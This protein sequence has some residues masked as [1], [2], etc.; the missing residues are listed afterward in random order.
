MGRKNIIPKQKD[1]TAGS[2]RK[3]RV[4]AVEKVSKR[5]KIEKSVSKSYLELKEISD[6]VD[7]S[8]D[9]A[10][11]S[12]SG[13]SEE[14]EGSGSNSDD[15]DN[16]S[17]SVPY[18]S[19]YIFVER[20]DLRT[21]INEV[22]SFPTK[23]SVRSRM[24][25]YR[26][27]KKILVDQ[28][29]KKRFKRSCFGHLRNLPEHL[30]FNGQLVHYLL[31]RLVKNDKIRHKMWFCINNKPACF[32]LKEFCLITGLD[33]SSYPSESKMKKVLAKGDDF[34]FKVTKNKNITVANLLHLIRGNKLNEDQNFKCCLLW[35]LHTMLLTK[36][37]MKVVDTKLIRMV[38]S[39]SF[40]EKYLWGKETFQLTMD[41]LKKKSNLK[42]QKEV[43]DE[44]Q[45]ASYALF[46]FPWAFM[47]WIYKVFPHLG[48]FA[49]KSMDEPLP[50]P[51]ILRWHTLKNDKI[52]EGDPFKYKG[53]VTE[54]VHPYIIPTVREMKMDYMITFDP[55]TNKV[56][57]NIL[58]GLKKE[59]EGVT[60]LTS[61][62]DSDDDG[63]LGGNPVGVRVGDDDSPS[64]SKDAARTSSLRDL[65]KSVAELEEAVLDIAVYIKEKRMK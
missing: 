35:F 44:K 26:E 51:R 19:R 5:K 62:E 65:H 60:I 61:N 7:S 9:V 22:G 12:V 48:E 47:I 33:C 4:A 34:C 32:G 50:I 31:L 55:Y 57:N 24:D 58:D 37:S 16:D 29:L 13:D 46:G 2:S 49:G 43:F 30:K 41:Y 40:F 1:D 21:I 39:L 23:I 28:E 18:L 27:F 3:R 53:K 64:T 42:K 36:Y 8:E 25:A 52:I 17:L 56:K 38:D 59:L 14:C 20:Y 6:Y 11:R 15:G 10:K 54:N 45:K 63:D